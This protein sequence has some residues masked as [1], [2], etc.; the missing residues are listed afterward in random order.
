MAAGEEKLRLVIAAIDKTTA[1]IR[2]INRR[3]ESMIAP[4]RKVQRAMR[5]LADESGLTKLG[6]GFAKLTSLA[7]NLALGGL[8]AG[9]GILEFTRRT[10]ESTD[11]LAELTRQ[12]GV[13]IERYQDLEFAAMRA[14][15]GNEAFAGSMRTLAKNVGML[16]LGSGPL[17]SILSPNLAKRLKGANGTG[18]ALVMILESLRKITDPLKRNAIAAKV[19]GKSGQSMALMAEL[20][21]EALADLIKES[22][23]FGRISTKT[24]DAAG[25]WMD[26]LDRLKVAAMRLGGQIAGELYSDLTAGTDALVAWVREHRVEI[27]NSAAEAVRQFASGLRTAGGFLATNLPK[28]QDTI[29]GLGGLET[30]LKG[31]A[32]LA[33]APVART[34]IALAMAIGAVGSAVLATGAAL[35]YMMIQ[36]EKV[37]GL[38]RRLLDVIDP[39]HSGSTVGGFIRSVNDTTPARPR[40]M[41]MGAPAG[42]SLPRARADS[43]DLSIKLDGAPA[44]ISR[45]ATSLPGVISDRGRAL[46][47]Q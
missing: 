7:K 14:G 31:I 3:I 40:T 35:A 39:F 22:E 6:R 37:T 23:G 17:A 15:I 16:K 46:A 24:A 13:G 1:P 38:K 32:A 41:N 43:I 47:A 34:A 29:T 25:T 26:S 11:S 18:G 30:V 20:S 2:A 21:S 36:L 5:S 12:L 42:G 19:F 33:L 45:A 9:A 8:A 27:I 4:V 44:R 28:L 10:A